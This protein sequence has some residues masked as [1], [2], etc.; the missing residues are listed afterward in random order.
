[1][2][3]QSSGSRSSSTPSSVT[4]CRGRTGTSTRAKLSA[5][6]MM[7]AALLSG[8][9][10]THLVP[11]DAP[12]GNPQIVVSD[13]TVQVTDLASAETKYGGWIGKRPIVGNVVMGVAEYRK[14]ISDRDRLVAQVAANKQ[15]NAIRERYARVCREDRICNEVALQVIERE[16]LVK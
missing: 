2:L 4:G 14:L 15:A 8:C 1:M 3:S 7:S 9:S 5:S 16:G 10:S 6:L 13:V 12:G 11:T